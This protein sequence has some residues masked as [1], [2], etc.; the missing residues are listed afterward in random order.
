MPIT[1]NVLYINSVQYYNLAQL[2]KEALGM[3]PQSFW[4]AGARL[5]FLQLEAL[6]DSLVLALVGALVDILVD[7]ML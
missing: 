4:L 3:C 7:A 6:V 2:T 5:D 1:Y